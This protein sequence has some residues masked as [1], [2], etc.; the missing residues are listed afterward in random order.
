MAAGVDTAGDE[1]LTAEL[2][3]L[4]DEHFGIPLEKLSDE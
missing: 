2:V 3:S 1:Q 4:F